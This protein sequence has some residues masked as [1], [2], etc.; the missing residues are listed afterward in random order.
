MVLMGSG[1]TAGGVVLL[2]VV[3]GVRPTE[4]IALYAKYLGVTFAVMVAACLIACIGPARRA[5]GINPTDA[6]RDA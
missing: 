3:A 5:L 2:L 1:I 4:E 6:L